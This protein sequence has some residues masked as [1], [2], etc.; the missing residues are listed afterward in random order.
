MYLPCPKVGK[1]MVQKECASLRG[2]APVPV[3][4]VQDV[5]ELQRILAKDGLWENA[6]LANDHVLLSLQAQGAVAVFW[7]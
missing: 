2:I 1:G 4:P 3:A 6:S 5:A 7:V